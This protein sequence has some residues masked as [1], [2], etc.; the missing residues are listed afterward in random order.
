MKTRI[1]KKTAFAMHLFWFFMLT[2]A[3]GLLQLWI[4]MLL[5]EEYQ[6]PMLWENIFEDGSLFFYSTA[7]LGGSVY[8][9]I[10][11]E[12]FFKDSILR[13]VVI[14]VFVI[15]LLI[16][17]TTY[18]SDL[19]IYL[20]DKHHAGFLH[21]YFITQLW[22]LCAA[23]LVSITVMVLLERHLNAEQTIGEDGQKIVDYV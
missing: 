19:S 12:T 10:S 4:T 1:V 14:V 22:C 5:M 17:G 15:V 9:V 8:T 2:I 16:S 20:S 23:L 3:C 13:H 18:A 7:I 11:N 6:A 21:M